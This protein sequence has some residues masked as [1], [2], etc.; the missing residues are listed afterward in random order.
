MHS[1]V[2][3]AVGEVETPAH[4]CYPRSSFFSVTF[5]IFNLFRKTSLLLLYCFVGINCGLLMA[6]LMFGSFVRN[7]FSFFGFMAYWPACMMSIL[8][9]LLIKMSICTLSLCVCVCCHFEAFL[10]IIA[11][12]N[13]CILYIWRVFLITCTLISLHNLP[14][15]KP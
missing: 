11:H 12:H 4:T 8:L 6:V 15:Q 5:A 13:F 10:S 7:F 2:Q 9:S 3:L 14:A 1:T